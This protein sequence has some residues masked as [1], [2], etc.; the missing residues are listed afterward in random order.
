MSHSHLAAISPHRAASGCC[1]NI[2]TDTAGLSC[3]ACSHARMLWAAHTASL[4]GCL[5]CYS[6]SPCMSLA[7]F[8]PTTCLPSALHSMICL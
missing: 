2:K 4:P 3:A 7:I 6:Q 1:T 5:S 8:A